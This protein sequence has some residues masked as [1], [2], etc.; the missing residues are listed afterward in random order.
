MI[1]VVQRVKEA[2][3]HVE[4]KLISKIGNGLLILLGIAKE[5]TA[6]DVQRLAEKCLNLRC[7]TDGKGK[8]NLSL[9]DVKGDCLVI[10]QITLLADTERGRRPDFSNA[11]SPDMARRLYEDFIST[12]RQSGIKV[13]GG[14]FGA[15]MH[16]SLVNDGPVTLILTS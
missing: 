5:D 15:Y 12:T 9:L 10:S 3:C 1:A 6:D 8:M 2:A 11:S 4:G 14:T 7:F 13:S 16:I